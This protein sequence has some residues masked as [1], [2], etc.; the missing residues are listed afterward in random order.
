MRGREIVTPLVDG[1]V[2]PTGTKT[3]SASPLRV[4]L[5]D[6][7]GISSLAGATGRVGIT[8]LPGKKRNGWTGP[9]WRDLDADLARLLELG[10][11]VL[12]LLVE[13]F[14]LES[15]RVT[16]LPAVMAE[17]GPELIRYPIRDPRIPTD[18]SAFRSAVLDLIER[19]RRGQFVAIA[20]RGGIDRSGMTAACLLRE[21]GI[22]ADEA[23]RRVQAARRGSI[24][25]PEQQK[26]VRGWAPGH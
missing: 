7:G 8:F 15:C 17:A 16:E 23:I 26:Y 6:L 4:D 18:D 22:D 25:L 3:S 24:T 21:V 19:V 9:H 11:D 2:A 20:C 12:F 14:E 13:D 10:V 1:L 5:L